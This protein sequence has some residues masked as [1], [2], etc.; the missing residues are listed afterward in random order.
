MPLSIIRQLEGDRIRTFVIG[1]VREGKS[2]VE[3]MA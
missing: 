1:E 3:L 2:G